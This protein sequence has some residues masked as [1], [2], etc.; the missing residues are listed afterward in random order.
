MYVLSP[1]KHV[2]NFVVRLIPNLNSVQI[3]HAYGCHI[4]FTLAI[5][6]F[7][8]SA[9]RRQWKLEM[10]KSWHR[11]ALTSLPARRHGLNISNDSY[12]G[13]PP[14]RVSGDKSIMV[15]I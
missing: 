5:M 6:N 7:D 9:V 11:E 4:S 15:H 8:S 14:E 13:R 3:I 2:D 10:I 12:P 1:D